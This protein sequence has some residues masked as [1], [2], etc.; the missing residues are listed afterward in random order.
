MSGLEYDRKIVNTKGDAGTG[1]RIRAGT[2]Q[3]LSI[4][5]LILVVKKSSMI[6]HFCGH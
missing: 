3:Y 4:S 1:I 6:F 5:I 2:L